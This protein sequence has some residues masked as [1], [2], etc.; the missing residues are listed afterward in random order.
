M[1]V[2]KC[3]ACMF[4]NNV[5][6]NASPPES[7]VA[8]VGAVI[9]IPAQGTCD[10]LDQICIAS[11]KTNAECYEIFDESKLQ[12]KN[13]TRTRCN[14]SL[15]L[16]LETT[17][18]PRMNNTIYTVFCSRP[19]CGNQSLSASMVGATSKLIIAGK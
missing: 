14:N 8:N 6:G 16:C 17:V 2:V 18:R 5:Y 3:G 11:N 15:K 19:R 12:E 4:I 10:T 9:Q 1:L 13:Y 7:I